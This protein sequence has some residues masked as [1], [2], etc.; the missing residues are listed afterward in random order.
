M[1]WADLPE[2]V[3]RPSRSR[4]EQ[5]P[6][7]SRR[8]FRK[9]ELCTCPRCKGKGLVGGYSG[10]PDEWEDDAWTCHECA[11][12]G[13][14]V[15][16]FHDGPE[17]E[18]A[19]MTRD[20]AGMLAAESYARECAARLGPWGTD[21]DDTVAWRMGGPLTQRRWTFGEPLRILDFICSRY[22]VSP[23]TMA[24]GK[25]RD[26]APLAHRVFYERAD[27]IATQED[28]WRALTASGTQLEASYSG[29]LDE[30]LQVPAALVGKRFDE[31]Q[32]PFVPVIEIW[33]LG[34]AVESIVP[35]VLWAPAVR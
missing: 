19:R 26:A 6:R 1:F 13:Q 29:V 28:S 17:G 32:S 30:I 2:K 5:L 15:V 20:R 33:R 27:E 23:M 14:V 16:S 31:L 3:L 35:I 10:D 22:R 11:C 7:D 21:V 18:A 12:Q 25:A 4:I 34:Y 24:F 9:V 8:R